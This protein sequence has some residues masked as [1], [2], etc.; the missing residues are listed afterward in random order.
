MITRLLAIDLDG[1]LCNTPHPEYGKEMWS[2]YYGKEY[3]HIGWWSKPESLDLNV[4]DIDCYQSMV[5]VI[6]K[7]NDN[8]TYKI[9]LTSRIPKVEEEIN[10]VLKHNNIKIDKIYTKSGKQDKGERLREIMNQF[11]ELNEVMVFD[12]NIEDINAYV[13]LR[14]QLDDNISFYIYSL[15][16]GTM[17]LINEIN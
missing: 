1:T 15:N 17:I 3:P 6:N 16:K 2:K 8:E 13:R 7:Y 5:N 10:K 9:I 12:D 11:P 4:F 14:D